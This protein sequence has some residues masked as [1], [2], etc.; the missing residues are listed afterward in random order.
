MKNNYIN[1]AVE[2]IE[3]IGEDVI[4]TSNKPSDRKKDIELPEIEDW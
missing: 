3:L 2:T 1:P 4:A